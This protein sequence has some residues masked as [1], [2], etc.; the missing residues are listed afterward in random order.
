MIPAMF[1]RL[2]ASTGVATMAQES[3]SARVSQRPKYLPAV[4]AEGHGIFVMRL[5]PSAG[6]SGASPCPVCNA[7][8]QLIPGAYFGEEYRETL[9]R[10]I[11]IFRKAGLAPRSAQRARQRLEQ[12]ASEPTRRG[13]LA[14]L[15][16]TGA[17]A[18]LEPLVPRTPDPEQ[19]HGLRVFVGLLLSLLSAYGLGLPAVP[20]GP[21]DAGAAT[22]ES[23]FY[24]RSEL[25]RPNLPEAG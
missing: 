15:D 8:G 5:D 20:S 10:V 22:S 2:A 3:I 7:S 19:N 25:E 17:L 24:L 14:A 4:C 16:E 13:V 12:I 6:H 11:E 23:G 21:A 18:A 9:E 1:L